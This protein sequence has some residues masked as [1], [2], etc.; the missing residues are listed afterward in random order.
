MDSEKRKRLLLIVAGV[1]ISAWLADRLVFTPLYHLW[2]AR[3]TEIEQLGQDIAKGAGLLDRQPALEAR[4]DGMKKRALPNRV[5]D[6]ETA[7]LESVSR[8][9]ND[10]HLSVTSV[11]PRW[12]PPEKESRTLE[13]QLEATG[14]IEALTKFAYDLESDPLPLRVE[15]LEIVSQDEKGGR[16]NLALR[17]TA[18]VFK[19]E[20]SS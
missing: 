20:A 5:A 11:K 10:S 16:L 18:L 4:W 14:T 17:F 2:T 7:V 9:T 3:S 6:A 1:C 13:I 8:W 12:N 15:D 19:E